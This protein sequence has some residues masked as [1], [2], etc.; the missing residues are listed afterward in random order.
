MG[1]PRTR[2]PKPHETDLQATFVARLRQEL[3]A[4][5]LSVL[6]FAGIKG[7]PPERTVADVL[8]FGAVPRLTFIAQC[9]TALNIPAS[10]LL[11]PR[12]AR[13]EPMGQIAK[14]PQRYRGWKHQSGSIPQANKVKIRA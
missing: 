5:Q 1:R 4:R 13:Q 7:A 14:L 2:K 10:D 9:A 3:D 6:Q 8:N 12:A 11:V